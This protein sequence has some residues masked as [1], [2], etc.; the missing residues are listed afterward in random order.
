MQDASASQNVVSDRDANER[1]DTA[2]TCRLRAWPIAE[3]MLDVQRVG[4][5]CRWNTDEEID[6]LFRPL[7]GLERRRMTYRPLA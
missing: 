6:W 3:I 7:T 5:R 1:S 4:L 2:R